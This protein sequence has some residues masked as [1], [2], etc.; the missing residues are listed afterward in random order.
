MLPESTPSLNKLRKMHKSDYQRLRDKYKWILRSQTLNVH[1]GPV[2]VALVRMGVRDFD[3]DNF[4]GG[5][6]PLIDALVNAG[7]IRGDKP[8]DI[9]KRDYDQVRAL[10]K[11]Q[12]RIIITIEDL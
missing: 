2:H 7:I 4:V 10:S 9:V 11:T 5:A 1:V 3:Y 6:K 12:E 8:T